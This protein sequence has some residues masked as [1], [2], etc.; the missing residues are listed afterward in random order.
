AREEFSDVEF[1]NREDDFGSL[2][3]RE[4]KL[5]YQPIKFLKKYSI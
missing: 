5:S 2:G 3:L 1:I 4:A